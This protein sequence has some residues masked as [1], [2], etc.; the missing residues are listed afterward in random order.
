MIIA[1]I[2]EAEEF[3][4]NHQNFTWDGWDIVYMVQDDYAEYLAA[5]IFNKEEKKW[6]RRII[7][8]YDGGWNIPNS[9]I[10]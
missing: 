1:T 2:D 5:G 6:Y 8:A 10:S 7:Y 4:N 3:V 9:V